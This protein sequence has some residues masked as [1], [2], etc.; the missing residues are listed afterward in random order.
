MNDD[1]QRGLSTAVC[2]ANPVRWSRILYSALV[3]LLAPEWICEHV[4]AAVSGDSV[5][6]NLAKVF[7][8][9]CEFVAEQ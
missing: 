1:I 8:T 3:S 2:R 7:F 9:A 5:I 4:Q 6:R